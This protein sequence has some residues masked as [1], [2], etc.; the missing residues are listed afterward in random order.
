MSDEIFI[1]KVV[2][3]YDDISLF[4][5]GLGFAFNKDDLDY[6]KVMLEEGFYFTKKGFLLNDIAVDIISSSELAI[7]E[8][9]MEELFTY[10]DE[11]EMHKKFSIRKVAQ[12]VEENT[13]VFLAK[14]S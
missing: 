1:Q 3:C 8:G 14:Q 4:L 7:F 13:R 10:D 11:P 2:G 6:E 5:K 12:L 9:K